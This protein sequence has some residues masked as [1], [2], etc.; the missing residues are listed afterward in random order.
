LTN[1]EQTSTTTDDPAGSADEIEQG[2][3]AL[4]LDPT[5][6][7][8]QPSAKPDLKLEIE[9]LDKGPAIEPMIEQPSD[10]DVK[11]PPDMQPKKDRWV[12]IC[13]SVANGEAAPGAKGTNRSLF[14]SI[15]RPF[16][17]TGD[18]SASENTA[19]DQTAEKTKGD[20][21]NA[22]NGAKTGEEKGE[23]WIKVKEDPDW[24][25]VSDEERKEKISWKDEGEWVNVDR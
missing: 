6:S 17:K 15:F 13:P 11:T 20:N 4:T 8:S 10:S 25:A 19:G 5:L 23:R 2:L 1:T 7:A 16:R 12:D 14:S 18:V 3:K 24:E 21:E 9:T 22:V